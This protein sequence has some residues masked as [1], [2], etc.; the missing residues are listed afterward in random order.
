M[1]NNMLVALNAILPTFLVIAV[2]MLARRRGMVGE[3]ELN[4]FNSV[5]F[6]IF[7]AA[8]LFKNVF[9]SDPGEAFDGRLA[10]FLAVC[11]LISAGLAVLLAEK[12]EPLRN[13]RGVMAQGI[14]RSNF[15][16]LG[17]PIVTSVFGEACSGMVSLMVAVVV[18]T[19]N[20]LAV[21]ALET[22]AGGAADPKKILKSICKNP[23]INA[24]LLGVICRLLK[25]PL[26]SFPPIKTT[27]GYFASASTPLCLFILGGSF[28][29]AS[30][31][32]YARSLWITVLGK[33]VVLPAIM[34]G[35]AV[36]LGFRGPALGVILVC[37]ASPTAVS[38][39]NMAREIGGDSEMAAGI[40]V[41]DTALSAVTLFFWIFLTR[42][43]GY[44]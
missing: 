27:L 10:A 28:A 18:P 9:D 44:I 5:A 32:S 26:Y 3:K 35:A 22:Y 41:V 31:K 7:L 40:V 21:I 43:L 29:P 34:V 38:S 24:A 42:Q 30:I 23:L 33:L 1:L 11:I 12:V 8:Q 20:V 36:A 13:R 17:I 19:F 39:F 6:R 15:V 4:K 25:L 37:F 16:L 14:F 2:G